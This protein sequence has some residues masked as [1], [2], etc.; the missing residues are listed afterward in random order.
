MNDKPVGKLAPQ[1]WMVSP[2]SRKVMAAL[3]S[4]GGD[5]RFV[6]G[7]VRNALA[8]RR[9]VDIDIATPLLPEDVILRLHKH[10]LRHIPMGLVHGTVTAM[11]DGKTFEITT[12]RKDVRG[13]GRH[14]DV[15][16]TDDWRIDASRRDFTINAL[17][18]TPEGDVY[19][20]FGGIEDLRVG[21]VR[22][23][24]NP[25]LRIREDVLRILRYFR[26]LAHFGSFSDA[27]PEAL[28][29]CEKLS[30]MI[31]KLSMERIRQEVFRL[32]ESDRCA[33]IW[34]MMIEHRIVTHFLPEATNVKALK[35]LVTLEY[36]HHGGFFPLRRIA[37]MMDTTQAGAEYVGKS[38]KLSN[39]QAAQLMKM[40]ELSGSVTAGMS[41]AAVRRLVYTVGNDMTGSLL[42][43]AAA[44]SGKEDDLFNLYNVANN[45]RPP[46]FPLLGEDVKQ[47]GYPEGPQI[48]AILGEVE[49]WWIKQDFAPG[50]GACLEKL[51]EYKKPA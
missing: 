38:L 46:R 22:F 7:C 11:V 24:G 36:I 8:N 29:A 49:Q 16:F 23:I 31:P 50:R 14:A 37:A 26:F 6:G 28:K 39:D 25:E 17:Y 27:D 21:R 43:L 5:A 15:M 1:E 4:H 44:K 18:A 19:D 47:I 45:F 3:C 13:Y 48:G 12:L 32:L 2:E 35:R 30:V 41:Q 40:I 20:F 51:Q 9:V 33:A 42:L 34:Q 10:Q